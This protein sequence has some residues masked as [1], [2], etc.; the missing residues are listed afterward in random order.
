[1]GICGSATKPQNPT[2][3]S[4]A[5]EAT[6][7]TPANPGSRNPSVQPDENSARKKEEQTAS[8]FKTPQPSDKPQV[9]VS[10][11]ED[12]EKQ[13][14][15]ERMKEIERQAKDR[16]EKQAQE[17]EKQ[18]QAEKQKAEQE[19]KERLRALEDQKAKEEL[20]KKQSQQNAKLTAPGDASA[21]NKPAES[22]ENSFERAGDAPETRKNKKKQKF[23]E[24]LEENETGYFEHFSKVEKKMGSEDVAFIINCLMGH[25]F[26][27]NL[28]NEELYASPDP[29]KTQSQRC[30][31]APSRKAA[32]CSRKAK[33][34]AASS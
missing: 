26:F 30:S 29:A 2:S 28:S 5:K 25:F 1:M 23:R 6:R 20:Q 32:T 21:K 18:R 8:A 10:Q 16:I 24:V 12:L 19:E 9:P 11:A 4:D 34:R 33:K 31:S 14:N 3:T 27:S 17:Q 7:S 22:H 13:R 15:A